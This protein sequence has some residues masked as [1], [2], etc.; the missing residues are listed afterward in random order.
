MLTQGW[1]AL[2]KVLI[3]AVTFA[4]PASDAGAHDKVFVVQGVCLFL[5]HQDAYKK[6]GMPI[7]V[8]G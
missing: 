1:T 4:D 2:L 5:H 7:K 3:E 6:E 8:D